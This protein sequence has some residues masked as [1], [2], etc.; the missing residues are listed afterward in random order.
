[1]I[2]IPAVAK[3]EKLEREGVDTR[4]RERERNRARSREGGMDGGN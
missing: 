1:M 3:G 4:G 2:K